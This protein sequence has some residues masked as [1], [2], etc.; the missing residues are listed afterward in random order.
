M[1]TS[2]FVG[3]A[4]DEIGTNFDGGAEPLAGQVL[5]EQVKDGIDGT[6]VSFFDARTVP[7]GTTV[8]TDS[9]GNTWTLEG[10]AEIVAYSTRTVVIKEPVARRSNVVDYDNDGSHK[11]TTGYAIIGEGEGDD[12]K[13]F[14]L[15]RT[16]GNIPLWEGKLTLKDQ[17]NDE[18][19][20]TRGEFCLAQGADVNRQYTL[21]L[22]PE[23]EPKHTDIA[24]GDYLRLVIQDGFTQE[25]A[26]FWLGRIRVTLSKQQDE[27]L[28]FEVTQ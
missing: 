12:G 5:W 7:E 15:Q 25:D 21:I 18:I 20:L 11:P 2:I 8:I 14:Y 19:L 22:D 27:Q 16:L 1:P 6:V 9:P 13:L 28:T 23:L 3:T 4:D 26:F 24:P 10:A 17:G